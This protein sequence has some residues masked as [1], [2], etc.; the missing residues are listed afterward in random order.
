MPPRLFPL[1]SCWKMG[2]IYSGLG[3]YEC[4]KECK[5]YYLWLNY[6]KLVT[7][8]KRGSLPENIS[9]SEFLSASC[10]SP[11]FVSL[12]LCLSL[13]LQLRHSF[14]SSACRFGHSFLSGFWLVAFLGLLSCCLSWPQSCLRSR[15]SDLLRSR[16]SSLACGVF[17]R[18]CAFPKTP[19]AWSKPCACLVSLT[20]CCCPSD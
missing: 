12:G 18:G 15:P 5:Y 8:K 3:T 10:R 17:V 20:R 16:S 4:D 9:V 14:L 19:P 11:S 1:V 6:A 7:R 13:G 2:L